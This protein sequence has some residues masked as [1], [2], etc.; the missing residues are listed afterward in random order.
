MSWRLY[1]KEVNT[2]C[3][4]ILLMWQV[5]RTYGKTVTVV[6]FPH[7]T[8]HFSGCGLWQICL[9]TCQALHPP[10]RFI[11]PWK[12]ATMIV[13]LL[14]VYM[15]FELIS[16]I[17]ERQTFNVLASCLQCTIVFSA[18][19]MMVWECGQVYTAQTKIPLQCG[20]K[21]TS[22][23]WMSD[24]TSQQWQRMA[25]TGSVITNVHIVSAYIPSSLQHGALL[26]VMLS[27]PLQW[28]NKHFFAYT[29]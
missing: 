14:C 15:T 8:A 4:V 24:N 7:K 27:L 13:T 22:N 2:Q 12:E 11:Q 9:C 29:M 26:I 17:L 23:T 16:S 18:F 20:W 25:S 19:W 1:Q 28:D 3:S 6:S 5:M 10:E 21:S